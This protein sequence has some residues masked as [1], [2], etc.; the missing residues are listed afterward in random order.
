MGIIDTVGT[1]KIYLDTNVFIYALEGFSEFSSTL[2][3][4]FLAIDDSK[5]Q[6]VTSELTL[7]ETLVK[8]LRDANFP[9]TEVYKQAIVSGAGLSVVSV[10]RPILIEAATLRAAVQL[11]LPDGI[12]VATALSTNCDYFLTNDERV[13]VY[14][15]TTLILGDFSDTK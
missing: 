14:G 3:E 15:L 9:L 8:P 6:A 5:V 10:N 11:K 12:H 1:K 2:T 7:A 13:K 4:L